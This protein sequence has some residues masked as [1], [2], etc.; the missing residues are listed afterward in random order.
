MWDI[1][2]SEL[3]SI[4]VAS[5]W[6]GV[7]V[8]LQAG[9]GAAAKGRAQDDGEEEAD[10]QSGDDH[11]PLVVGEEHVELEPEREGAYAVDVVADA[12]GEEVRVAQDAY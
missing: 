3:A 2:A 10:D 11:E 12:V 4:L 7:A 9:S 1:P 8:S 5:G 6:V